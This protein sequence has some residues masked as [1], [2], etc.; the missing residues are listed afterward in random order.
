MREKKQ[1]EIKNNEVLSN[2]IEN[3]IQK[4]KHKKRRILV[5]IVLAIISICLYISYGD[6]LFLFCK[7]FLTLLWIKTKLNISV[8]LF[9]KFISPLDI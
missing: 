7:N 1:E 2:K 4:K 5:L 9:N 8:L 3:K 6:I